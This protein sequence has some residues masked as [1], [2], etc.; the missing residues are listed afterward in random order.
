M[1]I[2]FLEFQF[3][4]YLMT[5]LK[6]WLIGK[7][8][9][10][11]RVWGQEEKGATKDEMAGWHHWLD[12]REWVNSG[13]WWWTG[14][15]GVLQF[16]GSQRVGHNWVNNLSIFSC[17]FSSVAQSC[18]ALWNPMDCSALGF[19]VHH[20]LL[21][22]AQT[23]VHRAGDAIWL[24]HL[25]SSPSP[26]AFNLS[27]HQ[28]LFQWVSSLHQVAKVSELLTLASILPMNIQDWFPLGLTG[29]PW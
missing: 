2:L 3:K 7:A 27:Q 22:L 8:S 18:P 28:G 16:M 21:E 10:A 29:L 25:L 26:P 20:Q 14:R 12:G 11:G 17:M 6:S 24:S 1:L 23:H 5:H 4:H 13:R 15:P 19:P 9:D